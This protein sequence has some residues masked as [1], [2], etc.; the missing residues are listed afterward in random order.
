MAPRAATYGPTLIR[1]CGRRL[2]EARLGCPNQL[3]GFAPRWIGDISFYDWTGMHC[4]IWGRPFCSGDYSD[5]WFN[6]QSHDMV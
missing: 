2:R 6:A 1:H 3:E 4:M 5:A